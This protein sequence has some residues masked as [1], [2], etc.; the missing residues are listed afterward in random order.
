ML[1][2]AQFIVAKIWNH[3]RC[4][5]TDDWIKKM[6]YVHIYIIYV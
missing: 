3:P 4:P 5:A 2:A 1:T 6:Q